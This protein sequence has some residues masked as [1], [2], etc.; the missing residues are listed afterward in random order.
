[1]VLE[2]RSRMDR[3]LCDF[4]GSRILPANQACLRRA[5]SGHAEAILAT[6]TKR[7]RLLDAFRFPGFRPQE[8]VRGIF[9]DPRARIITLVRRSKKRRVPVA[10]RCDRIGT[11]AS[12]VARAILPEGACA[13]SLSSRCGAS[14]AAVAAR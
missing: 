2:H 4:V 13:Y 8:H 12:S 6:S 9:G 11:I 3:A 5:I 10:E 14:I 1:G 7:R